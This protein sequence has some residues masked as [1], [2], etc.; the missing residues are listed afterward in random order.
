[1]DI[2]TCT[3]ANRP[4][5]ERWWPNFVFYKYNNLAFACILSVHSFG[6]LS[7]FIKMHETSKMPNNRP[8]SVACAACVACAP[9]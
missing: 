9:M 7:V 6:V 8:T 2:D 4:A 5:C 3:C 1:M